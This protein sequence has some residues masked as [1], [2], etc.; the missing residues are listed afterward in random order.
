MFVGLQ[1]TWKQDLKSLSWRTV[2]PAAGWQMNIEFGCRHVSW[3]GGA[4]KPEWTTWE[5]WTRIDQMSNPHRIN[6]YP[7][8]G[9][10]SGSFHKD[11]FFFSVSVHPECVIEAQSHRR[12]NRAGRVGQIPQGF[13]GVW[14]RHVLDPHGF[15]GRKIILRLHFLRW[16]HS[17]LEQNDTNSV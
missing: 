16:Q 4:G 7:G 2:G 1:K 14:D 12:R 6:P 9:L 5:P 13:K 15:R 11:V 3:F 17:S 8:S 10:W